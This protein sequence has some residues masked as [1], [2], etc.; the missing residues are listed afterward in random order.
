MSASTSTDKSASPPFAVRIDKMTLSTDLLSDSNSNIFKSKREYKSG[1]SMSSS[2][3]EDIM[4]VCEANITSSKIRKEKDGSTYGTYVI[5]VS[6]H[7][8]PKWSVEKRYHEFR[9]LRRELCIVYSY[10]SDIPFPKKHWFFNLSEDVLKER[11]KGLNTFLNAMVGLDPQP[12]ELV[13]FLDA[14]NNLPGGPDNNGNYGNS[15]VSEIMRSSSMG[16]IYSSLSIHDFKLMKVLGKGSFG[17]VFLVRPNQNIGSSE[18]FAMKVLRKADVV[19]RHQVEHTRTERKILE[20]VQHNYIISLKYAFQTNDKLYMITDY[21][22][23][24][25]LFFHLKRMRRFTEGMMRFYSAQIALALHHLHERS[26]LYRD[27][28]PENILLDKHGNCKLT[29]FGLSKIITPDM[30]YS[31]NTFCGTPEYLAP[32]MLIHK[33]RSSGYSI[34]IDWWALGIVCFEFL[35]GWPPF[36]DRDF[37]KMCEKILTRTLK[38]PSKYNVSANA[39]NIIK[40]FLQ[41]D[42]RDRMCCGRASPGEGLDMLQTHPFYQGFEW[43]KLESGELIPPFIPSIGKDP[44]D[45]RN[46]DREFTKLSVKDSPPDAKKTVI[47]DSE[48]QGFS[49]SDPNLFFLPEEKSQSVVMASSTKPSSSG[50]N[51]STINSSISR[52]SASSPKCDVSHSPMALGNPILSYTGKQHQQHD[53]TVNNN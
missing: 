12:R 1:N 43:E 19:R 28:K 51:I 16:S 22:S 37:S 11:Q 18:L 14:I 17:K 27:L 29:D 33:Q 21:C 5:Q 30:D 35:T 52:F 38:F 39:Q 10:L 45:T 48:F 46:F 8:G 49:F 24:G 7:A 3:S 26:I 9:A 25:E 42:P 53:T 32:E 44:A 36:F 13:L 34:E 47:P 40:C 4:A 41:R 2:K 20:I 6:L 31:K 23:G 15:R 50:R